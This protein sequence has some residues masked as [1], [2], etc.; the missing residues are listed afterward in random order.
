MLT[1]RKAS[2]CNIMCLLYTLYQCFKFQG[3]SILS[4]LS[5]QFRLQ[6]DFHEIAMFR[7]H[8][9][10]DPLKQ[11]LNSGLTNIMLK[12]LFLIAFSHE[13]FGRGS[14]GKNMTTGRRMKRIFC[15]P[16]NPEIRCH[17]AWEKP[18]KASEPGTFRTGLENPVRQRARA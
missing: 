1:V 7:N 3:A 11:A 15:Y 9:S 14:S 4:A 18:Q 16:F 2:V 6:T 10:P 13:Y 8:G 12:V 5:W 17:I